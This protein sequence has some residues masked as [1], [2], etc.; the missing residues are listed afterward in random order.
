MAKFIGGKLEGVSGVLKSLEFLE[1]K[2]A[3]KIRRKFVSKFTSMLAKAV[4]QKVPKLEDINVAMK[5]FG[6]SSGY[7]GG[8]LKKAIGRKV[9]TYRK[10]RTT[11]GVVGARTGY[12]IQVGKRTRGKNKGKPVFINPTQYFHLAE[13]GTRHSAARPSLRPSFDALKGQAK[14]MLTQIAREE[15]ERDAAKVAKVAK[16]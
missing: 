10:T 16:K 6:V 4:K 7:S 5:A 13:Y 11:F 14:P 9:K 8:Q 1:K 12:K 2:T 3:D 15:I